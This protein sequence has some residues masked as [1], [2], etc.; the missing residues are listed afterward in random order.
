M[1]IEIKKE[2]LKKVT[3]EVEFLDSSDS[4]VKAEVDIGVAGDDKDF[5]IKQ[6][7]CKKEAANVKYSTKSKKLI[8]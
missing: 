2:N 5:S 8:Q 4:R 3:D 7:E 6:S 1:E